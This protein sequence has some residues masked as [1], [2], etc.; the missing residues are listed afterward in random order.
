M[1]RMLVIGL[2]LLGVYAEVV[3][4][5]CA[6]VL[7]RKDTVSAAHGSEI[8]TWSPIAA[9]PGDAGFKKCAQR[10]R[11]EAERLSVIAKLRPEFEAVAVS[12]P[13]VSTEGETIVSTVRKDGGMAIASLTCLPSTVNPR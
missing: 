13:N 4:A 11:Q 12:D 10:A 7:W 5:E 9:H 1:K 3:K 6:W 2:M 8:T